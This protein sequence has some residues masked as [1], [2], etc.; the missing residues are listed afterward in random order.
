[1]NTTNFRRKFELEDVIDSTVPEVDD[2]LGPP[3]EVDHPRAL[4]SGIEYF[5]QLDHL[6]G[7]AIT[8]ARVL[9]QLDFYRQGL[10]HFA[11]DLD[12]FIDAEFKETAPSLAG[13][14]GDEQ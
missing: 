13:P 10:G 11:P 8:G 3:D 1:M 6:L 12:E 5:E 7:V 4:Q 9:V 14:D 2:I